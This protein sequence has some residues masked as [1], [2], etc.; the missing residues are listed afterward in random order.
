MD[1]CP[2]CGYQRQAKDVDP[3][4]ECARCGIVFAK[5]AHY[6]PEPTAD[7]AEPIADTAVDEPVGPWYLRLKDRLMEL[8]EHPDKT[9]LLAQGLVLAVMVVW[10]VRLV[11]YKVITAEILY[12]FLH[13]VDLPI[14]EFGHLLF[15]PLGEWMMYLGGSLFQCLLPAILGVIFIWRQRDPFAACFCLWWTGE[16]V[17]DVAP[18]IYD[19][20]LMALPLTGEWNDEVAEL[21]AQRHDWHNILEPLGAV[22]SAPHIGMLAHGLGAGIMGLACLWA[23]RWLWLAWRAAETEGV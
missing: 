7:P 21:H 2:K 19:A 8:P 3:Y 20:K 4:A 12:S 1:T 15:R 5:Y 9:K 22:N 17:V 18:Y 6:H 16:N 14:H 11:T 10:G 23:G 13:N